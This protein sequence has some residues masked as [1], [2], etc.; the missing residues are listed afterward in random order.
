MPTSSPLARLSDIIEAEIFVAAPPERVFQ[1][2][3]DPTQMPRWWGQ[4]GMYRITE[5]TADLRPGGF[6]HVLVNWI[7]PA[8][9][10][11]LER[12]PAHLDAIASMLA[13][14]PRPVHLLGEG[15]T[16]HEK[17]IP[18]DQPDAIFTPEDLTMAWPPELASQH[19]DVRLSKSDAGTATSAVRL[20]HV[21]CR[22]QKGRATSSEGV[23]AF[24]LPAEIGTVTDE[25]RNGLLQ[26]AVHF[27]Q[28]RYWSLGP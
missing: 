2:L 27:K 1:A 6:A 10:N 7:H 9:E 18:K 13:R 21:P 25:V 26:A 5:C 23:T 24:A 8:G 4:A 3:T 14:S 16:Y 11:W 22:N 20:C 19:P 17:F 12:E 28:P 15:I